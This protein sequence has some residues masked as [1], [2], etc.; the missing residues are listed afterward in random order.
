M[1]GSMKR[2]GA[3]WHEGDLTFGRGCLGWNSFLT[4]HR[5]CHTSQDCITCLQD[6]HHAEAHGARAR[7][8]GKPQR[9]CLSPRGGT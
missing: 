8:K 9:E 4:P 7:L 1:W 3:G 5:A 6:G 2:V